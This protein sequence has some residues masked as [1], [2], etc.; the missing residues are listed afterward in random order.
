MIKLRELRQ[1]AFFTVSLLTLLILIVILVTLFYYLTYNQVAA[2]N[3]SNTITSRLTAQSVIEKVDRNFYERFG[4]VQAFAFNKLAVE[5]AE[6]GMPAPGMQEFINTMTA[7]YVLYDLMMICNRQGQVI[8]FNTKDKNGKD[9]QSQHYLNKSIA[10]EDWFNICMSTE[11]PK[12]GAW[13]SDFMENQDVG[14]IYGTTGRGMAYAAPIR[15]AQGTVVGAWYNYASWKEVTEDIR[16]EAELNLQKD[17]PGAFIIMT[18]RTGEI[19][20]AQ[21]PK[22]L[23]ESV[24]TDSQGVATPKKAS[25]IAKE[26]YTQGTSKSKGAY[27]FAGKG[28]IAAAFIPKET[29][30]WEVFFSQKNLLAVGVCLLVVTL[31]TT[32]VYR[33]FKKNIISKIDTIR[34]LQDRLSKGE[35]MNVSKTNHTQ[36]EFGQMTHSLSFLAASLQQKA[37]FAD[38]ISKGN[39]TVTMENADKHDVLGNSLLNMRTQLQVA[40]ESD[41]QRSW[42]AEGLAQVAVTLRS[43]DSTEQLYSNIIK[44]IVNYLKANQGGI[45]LTD[46]TEGEQ[47]ISLVACYAYDKKKFV[48][49]H[50]N[51]GEGLIGQSIIEKQTVYLTEIPKDFIRITSG[52]GGALPSSLLIVPLKSNDVVHGAVEIASFQTFKPYEIEFMEKLCESISASLSSIRGTENTGMLVTR[53]Q[54]QTEEMKAQEEE[55]RQNMEELSATQEEM[56]R[57]EKEYVA[58]IRILEKG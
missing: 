41:T 46:E 1:S 3:A 5:S 6:T 55:M 13:F 20:S 52:L 16:K 18:K 10:Q 28:W 31:T 26:R 8:A 23:K 32:Y 21:D 48:Q 43:F 24:M 30:S 44:F 37:A 34:D 51:P 50:L 54:Q 42:M 39:L 27:T 12:G 2:N 33:F 17:H 7:Y 38:E 22:L 47:K 40:K 11:G 35:I 15:N 14:K 36:D 57:K 49:K 9:I 53:L 45:F 58:R 25:L 56:I 19:I 29:I 4:D